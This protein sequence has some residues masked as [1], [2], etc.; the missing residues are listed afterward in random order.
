ME[1][2]SIY[3]LETE[4][5]LPPRAI[6]GLVDPDSISEDIEI[7]TVGPMMGP[8]AVFTGD[9]GCWTVAGEALPP[10]LSGAISAHAASLGVPG[11]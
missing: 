1:V 6:L 5:N 9:M 4:E 7:V 10:E 11:F 2:M 8:L 3:V